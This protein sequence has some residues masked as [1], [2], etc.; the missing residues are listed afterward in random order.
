MTKGYDVAA[1][2]I[3][4]FNDRDMVIATSLEEAVVI[5][6]EYQQKE[7]DD[8]YRGEIIKEVELIDR[9]PISKKY[10]ESMNEL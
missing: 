1:Y 10:S 8:V 4:K 9:K 3:Y 5:Y 2:Q 7:T 6:R